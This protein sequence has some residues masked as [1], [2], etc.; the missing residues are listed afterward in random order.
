MYCD[1]WPETCDLWIVDRSTARDFTVGML[2]ECES[3]VHY[4]NVDYVHTSKNI[5]KI[6][7]FRPC[8]LAYF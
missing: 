5:E 3:L 8:I 4:D 7:V 1:L 2:L 6:E